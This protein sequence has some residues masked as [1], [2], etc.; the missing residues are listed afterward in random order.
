MR[1][2]KRYKVGCLYYQCGIA[3]DLNQHAVPFIETW[4]YMGYVHTPGRS[5]DSCDKPEHFYYFKKWE[6]GMAHT[7]PEKWETTGIYVPS[8]KQALQSR[9][10]WK[11]LMAYGLPRLLADF[12]E[13]ERAR[14]QHGSDSA[15][16]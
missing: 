16:Q 11:Q 8:L 6:P 5:S 9:L 15:A 3:S 14:R 1:E 10:T 7:P 4:V 13:N 2:N 12:A